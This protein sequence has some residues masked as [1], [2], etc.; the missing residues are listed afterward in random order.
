MKWLALF[1]FCCAVVAA[2]LASAAIRRL[3]GF[4]VDFF[5]G[6][7]AA[8]AYDKLFVPVARRMSGDADQ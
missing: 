6:W 4:D 5:V 1:G 3:W 8:M 7:W 2:L